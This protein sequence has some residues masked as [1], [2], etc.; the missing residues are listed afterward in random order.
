MTVITFGT[1]TP[2]I[3]GS[4]RGDRGRRPKRVPAYESYLEYTEENDLA[5]VGF[6]KEPSVVWLVIA[7]AGAALDMGTAVKAVS[8]L[9]KA[10]SLEAGGDLVKFTKVVRALE[11]EKEITAEIARGRREGGRGSEGFRG[12]IVRTHQGHDREEGPRPARRPRRV[13]GCC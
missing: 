3:V 2:A 8:K 1:A 4:G 10:A 11:K 13:Q 7:V 12:G 5:R 6:A 9:G